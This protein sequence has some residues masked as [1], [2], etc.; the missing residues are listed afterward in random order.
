MSNLQPIIEDSFIQYS[1]AVLQS[2]ALI[3]VRD[4]LKPSA[5]QIFY[6]MLS[7]KLTSD[8]PYKKTANAVGMAMADFYI[9][10]DSSCE[11]VIMRAGQPFAMRYP[12]IDVK[13][14]AGSLIESGNWAAM[15]YTESR[16]SKLSN[17]LFAD[18]NKDTIS[19]WRDSYD[20]T[21]Q[22]PAVLPTK[23]YYNICNGS[24]GIGIGMA[25]SVPQ[26][27]LKELNHALEVLLLNPDCNFDEIYCAPDFATGAILLNESAVKESM[28]R[29][30][31]FA[32]KLRSVVEYDKR[33][34]C[35]VVTEIPY[36]VYTN[37]ICGELEAIIEDENNPGI[38]RFN[39]L[40][41]ATPLIKIYLNK[42]TNPE[43][44]LKYLYKNTSLQSHYGINFTML[45]KGRFPKV[46]TWKEMLQAHIDHEKEVYM[47]GFEF[48][49]RKIEER[50]HIIE[51]LLKVIEDIDNV[52]RLI[53]T[54]EST[55]VARQRLME[56]YELDEAQTKAILDMKLSRL[57]H[58]EV[59]K[60]KNEKL[61]LE[62]ERNFIYNIIRNEELFNQELIKGWRD[63]A[64]K[65]GDARR[66]QILNISKDD[67]EPKETQELLINLSNQ[68][69]IYVSTVS[70]LYTQRRGGVGN[71]FKMS[72]GEYVISTASGTNL[73]TVLLFSNLGNCYHIQ[74]NELQ[75]ETVLPI[76][77]LVDLGPNEQIKNLVFLNKS[78]QKN[79]I[80]F[81][82]KN[83]ILKKSQLSEY[84][85]KRKIGVKAL[86]LDANDEIVSILFLN[87]ERIGM[88][89]ARGQFIMCET[90]DIRA[91]GRVARGVKGITLNE[92]DYLVSAHTIAPSTKELL[93]ISEKGYIKRTSLKEFTVTGRGTK[94]SRIHKLNDED[95]SLVAFAALTNEKETI[96]VSSNA[97]IKINLNEVNLLSKGAQGTKSIKLSNSK[98]IGLL[99]F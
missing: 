10:G 4:G 34:N 8:K 13:G 95:D 46:F 61:K 33:E 39:D 77:S 91:I 68:N 21:K 27:N 3:D 89:T 19:E 71:K 65:F 11:G 79:Y 26:Y 18:I 56:R 31:G 12:L 24:M 49:L 52:V 60:L 99:I 96:I 6:S 80:I 17:I 62:N 16:L 58:L 54:S 23:G 48:D 30:T 72:K 98:V 75:F 38:D 7:N 45:D 74:P 85:I 97:Q 87:E 22:Y 57:A 37:T 51:G 93:T 55:S 81:L 35:F 73:D 14:N 59:E 67:E 2:R 20:N 32:C 76:E 70:T 47:R 90:K 92:G 42:K 29:G 40:T 63:V 66:T 43:R 78:R 5:R 94:G 83:G 84:N 28:K 88:M 50:L 82:T 41:G 69:N 86:N 15:R 25:C 1:G 64:S 44:A 9:H 36:G 53:K